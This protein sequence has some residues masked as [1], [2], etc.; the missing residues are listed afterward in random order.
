MSSPLLSAIDRESS[1]QVSSSSSVLQGEDSVPQWP[2]TEHGQ[3][4]RGRAKVFWGLNVARYCVCAKSSLWRVLVNNLSKMPSGWSHSILQKEL[5]SLHLPFL[6]LATPCVGCST[7][8][9]WYSFLWT[10][11]NKIHSYLFFWMCPHLFACTLCLDL[12]RKLVYHKSPLHCSFPYCL[13]PSLIQTLSV[14][15]KPCS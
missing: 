3:M 14:L 9:L 15:N 8:K 1:G 11:P 6:D 2:G 10:L 5:A 4:S 7:Q 13:T 12:N